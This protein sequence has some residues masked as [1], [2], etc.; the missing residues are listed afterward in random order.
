[1][2]ECPVPDDCL[3]NG[4][5]YA[6]PSL[7]CLHAKKRSHRCSSQRS[8]QLLTDSSLPARR[9]VMSFGLPSN[10]LGSHPPLCTAKRGCQARSGYGVVERRCIFRCRSTYQSREECQFVQGRGICPFLSSVPA[11]LRL[12]KK[13]LR[14]TGLTLHYHSGRQMFMKE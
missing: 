5:T 4:T 7:A 11:L 10:S 12:E 6:K 1:M 2:E 9:P 8:S 13:H 14:V 3:Q